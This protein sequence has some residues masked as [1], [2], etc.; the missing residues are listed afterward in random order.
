NQ[1][2]KKDFWGPLV[3]KS[4]AIFN[5]AT[6]FVTNIKKQASF[7][8]RHA[9]CLMPCTPDQASIKERAM[10]STPATRWANSPRAFQE[11]S[12]EGVPLD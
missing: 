5:L 4:V 6:D 3:A 7:L 9:T 11:D 1:N 12:I 10:T 8:R 2:K